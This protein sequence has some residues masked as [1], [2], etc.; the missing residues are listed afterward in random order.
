MKWPTLEKRRKVAQ[1]TMMFNVVSGHQLYRFPPSIL[2]ER[3]QGTRQILLKK[4]FQVNAKTSKYSNTVLLHV[5]SETG[6]LY[7]GVSLKG[8]QW[9]LSKRL[10]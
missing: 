2:F 6:N 3:R 4:L 8:S 7:Q 1:L 5:Q 10:S 9:R